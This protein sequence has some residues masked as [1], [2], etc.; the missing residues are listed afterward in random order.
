MSLIFNGMRSYKE[1]GMKTLDVFKLVF[2]GFRSNVIGIF[3]AIWPLIFLALAAELS[4]QY[5]PPVV[6]SN[7]ALA[8]NG[9]I[10]LVALKHLF[11]KQSIAIDISFLKVFV[12]WFAAAYVSIVTTLGYYLLLVPGVL[13]SCLAVFFFNFYC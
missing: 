7:I 9:V 6:Y 4:R 8:L 1:D 11:I 5:L 10:V 13:L 12:F 2:Q 3:L